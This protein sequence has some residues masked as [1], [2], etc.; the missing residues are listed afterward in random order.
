MIC[1]RCIGAMGGRKTTK[2]H[3]EELSK[4]GKRGAKKTNAKP[5]SKKKT[6]KK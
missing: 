5:A 1:P 6:R 4:W 2:K 3:K